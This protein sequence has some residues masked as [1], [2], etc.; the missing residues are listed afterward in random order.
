MRYGIARGVYANEA[1]D[2]TAQSSQPVQQG[3]N[4]IVEVWTVSFVRPRSA[5]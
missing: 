3:L 1:G 2:G 4:A 5:R